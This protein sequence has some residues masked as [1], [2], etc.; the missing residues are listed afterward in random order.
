MGRGG[1]VDAEPGHQV[2]LGQGVGDLVAVA[3]RHAAGHDE[4]GARSAQIGQLEH[5]VDGLLAGRLNEGAGVDHDQIGLGRRPRRGGSPDPPDVPPACPS[6]PGSWGTPESATST[7]SR[8][9]VL[10]TASRDHHGGGARRAR[11][12]GHLWFG[13]SRVPVPR[14]EREGFEPSDPVTQVNSLAVNPIRPLSH[15]SLRPSL[16]HPDPCDTGAGGRMRSSR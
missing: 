10:L 3:L 1:E 9:L 6:Q 11:R 13:H 4:A 5:G 2:H 14:A 16:G 12:S 8:P 15:L 7:D